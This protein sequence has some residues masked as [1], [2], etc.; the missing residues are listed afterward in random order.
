MEDKILEKYEKMLVDDGI[1]NEGTTL[2]AKHFTT[3]AGMMKSS[4]TL[5]ELKSKL[6]TW[7]STLN[8]QFDAERFKTAA[9]MKETGRK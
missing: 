6:I 7:C 3:L 4:K 5:D 1:I 2:T 9:G 8:P